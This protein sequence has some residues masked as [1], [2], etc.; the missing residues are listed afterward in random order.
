M[1]HP[2]RSVLM[3]RSTKWLPRPDCPISHWVFLCA[4]LCLWQW[5]AQNLSFGSKIWQ[6]ALKETLLFMLQ[7]PL[8]S[9]VLCHLFW[10]PGL[11]QFIRV[12]V[13]VLKWEESSFLMCHGFS[14]YHTCVLNP[15]LQPSTGAKGRELHHCCFWQPSLELYAPAEPPSTNPCSSY[16]L[17]VFRWPLAY[18]MVGSLVISFWQYSN[19]VMV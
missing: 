7:I 17:N 8:T 1:R 2:L 15:L 16:S 13:L 18:F 3:W 10:S 9:S 5:T 19:S 4:S 14:T 12:V 6:P 11:S